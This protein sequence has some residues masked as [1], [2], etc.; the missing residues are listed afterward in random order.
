MQAAWASQ[1]LR[2]AE[3]LVFPTTVLCEFCWVLTKS[4]HRTNEAVQAAIMTLHAIPNV[5]TESHVVEAGLKVLA[6]GGDF[7]D[8]AIAAAGR[9]VG[10]ETF[11]TFDRQAAQLVEQIGIPTRLLS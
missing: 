10:G 9:Q 3:L 1:E 7:A 5:V 6:A 2:R 8:G 4:Y 11:V